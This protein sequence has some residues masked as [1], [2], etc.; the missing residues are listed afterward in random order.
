MTKATKSTAPA[1][2][3][4]EDPTTDELAAAEA[5]RTI[6]DAAAEKVAKTFN[7]AGDIFTRA[8]TIAGAASRGAS[9]DRI[10]ARVTELRVRARF[11]RHD[12]DAIAAVLADTKGLRKLKL[13]V[14]KSSMQQYATT[15]TSTV[16]AG[17]RPTT[18]TIEAMFRVKSTGGHAKPLAAL[19]ESLGDAEGE[20][21]VQKLVEGLQDVLD[22]LRTAKKDSTA[23]NP[24]GSG[25]GV[26]GEESET[27]QVVAGTVQIGALTVDG[28]EG[29]LRT[30]IAEVA[31]WSEDDRDRAEAALSSALAATLGEFTVT[32]DELA[33][34]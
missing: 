21:R 24:G 31:N 23:Q 5:M 25:T 15:W 17:V 26:E 18:E 22:G 9:L 8:R 6:E 4:V 19:I 3:D 20:A 12:D 2:A 13:S 10:A 28:L 16:D 1:I 29:V 7:D 27:G 30:F 14:S 33:A 11:P 34:V 32:E